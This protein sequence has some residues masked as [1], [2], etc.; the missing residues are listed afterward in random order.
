MICM[1]KNN[2]IK[3]CLR[4]SPYKRAQ[5]STVTSHGHASVPEVSS[6]NVRR[7]YPS[8]SNPSAHVHSHSTNTR[9]PRSFI[10]SAT[11]VMKTYVLR[12]V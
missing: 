2:K 6:G 11:S 12:N 1:N 9:K 8:M 3:Y 5:T 7:H 10:T 4:S